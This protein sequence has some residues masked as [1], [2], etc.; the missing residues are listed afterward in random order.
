MPAALSD[1][2]RHRIITAWK[3]RRLTIQELASRFDVGEA[4]VKRQQR[5]YR[6]TGT[7]R[8]KP[9]GGGSTP[10]IGKDQEPLVEALVQHHPDWREDEYAEALGELYGIRASAV[11]VGR[12][13]R[14]LGYSVKKRR[15]SPK[16]ATEPTSSN[17]EGDSSPPSKPSPLRVWFLWT[18]RA[19]T[20]R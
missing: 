5:R 8:P 13:I 12:A 19:P 15:S 18:K 4:T 14:R 10:I 9:H 16:S 11:T 2:L 3:K 17:A 1:D 7:V 6:E 20:A